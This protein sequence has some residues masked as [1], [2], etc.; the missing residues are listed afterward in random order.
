MSGLPLACLWLYFL[1]CISQLVPATREPH[2]SMGSPLS[3]E[4]CSREVACLPAHAQG[5]Q[6]SAASETMPPL[7]V[8]TVALT[9]QEAPLL[10]APKAL[11]LWT[12][13]KSTSSLTAAVSRYLGLWQSLTTDKEQQTNMSS[14]GKSQKAAHHP[15]NLK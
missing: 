14:A 12:A 6:V 2:L 8:S 4:L 1:S 7:A 9:V 15:R 11:G 13:P 3:S 10:T 5:P